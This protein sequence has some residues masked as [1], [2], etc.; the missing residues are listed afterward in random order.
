[1]VNV[2]LTVDTE[3]SLGGALENSENRP[4]NPRKI[5]SW[6]DQ[7]RILRNA[8]YHAHSGEPRLARDILP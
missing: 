8:N 1:M 3:C 6:A 4:V 7:A 2:F 5:D